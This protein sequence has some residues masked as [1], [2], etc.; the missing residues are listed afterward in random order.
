MPIKPNRP[1]GPSPGGGRL[2]DRRT[3][4]K[5]AAAVGTAAPASTLGSEQKSQQ[6]KQP[7]DSQA[8]DNK[9]SASPPL[10]P[11]SL[12]PAVHFQA[13]PS[14]TA[15]Y[16]ASL[17]EPPG[18]PPCDATSVEPW[19]GLVPTSPEEIAFLPVH[20]LA[21][22]IRGRHLSPVD[23]TEIYLERIKRLNARLLCMV[24]PMEESARRA[25]RQAAAEINSG[26]Y[27]GPLHGI[28]W[29]V[30]DLFSTK[31]TRTTWGTKPY[32]N[33]VIDEDAEVVVRLRNAG[34]ILIAK[35]STGT[36]AW[37]DQWFG[38][39]TL[40]PWNLE[41]GSSGS[42]A[43]PGSATAAGCVGF[44]I[45][46][47]T[48]GSIVS[49][50]RRCGISALRPTFGRVSRS[51]CMTLSWSLDKVGP[52]CRTIEDCALVFAAIHGVD[53]KDAA[54][55]TAPFCFER[56]TDLAQYS[57]GYSKDAQMS[58]VDKLGEM[59][60]QPR[61][62]PDPPNSKVGEIL[63]I[64]AAAAFDDFVTNHLD[65]QMVVKKWLPVFQ[66]VRPIT[67]IDYIH[68]Q[69]RRYA[70]MLEMQ[71]YMKGIDMYVSGSGDVGLT[72][73]TGHPAAIVPFTIK[74]GQPRCATLI[75]NLFADDKILSV[76]HAYQSATEWHLAHPTIE[77]DSDAGSKR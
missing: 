22:L 75:G 6:S 31:G 39:K 41:Q 30:K 28:P 73:L 70:L 46:T 65:E 49:P 68:A 37:A 44:A 66:R 9:A 24:T 7:A 19:S 74:D 15:A 43:G 69:R 55:L 77:L 51:G 20:R 62:L 67:A 12:G 72:N 17:P 3:F 50:A 56:S 34:A 14:G 71:D 4:V 13:Y 25:A 52:M 33:R 21:A 16:L 10:L 36:L 29:G 32:E 47:E 8:D 18:G 48:T 64:E 26:N 58:F 2:C 40:N 35:L 59:G 42:S 11:N 27:R 63:N 1:A 38:G 53:D 60:A 61:L 5:L 45:G 76:A 54:T 23:L 57:I